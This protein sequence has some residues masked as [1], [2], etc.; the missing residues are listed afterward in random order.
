LIHLGERP[1]L[2]SENV[3]YK[4]H[5]LLNR[6]RL[7]L[8]DMNRFFTPFIFLL[9]A[10]DASAYAEVKVVRTE[11]GGVQVSTSQYTVEFSSTGEMRSLEVAGVEFLK[12]P[13]WNDTGGMFAVDFVPPGNIGIVSDRLHAANTSNLKVQKNKL[14]VSGDRIT[15][16]FLFRESGFDVTGQSKVD[17][18]YLIY[19]P[20][21]N[22]LR[23][24]DSIT[25]RAVFMIGG[26]VVGM[27]QEGMRWPTKQGPMLR[28]DER[29]DGYSKFYWWSDKYG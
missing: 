19:F 5:L 13:A 23:S 16:E 20:S 8:T 26:K 14:T 3:L 21:D 15:L 25:D 17:R 4:T 10:A 9:L 1:T 18:D 6:V 12:P 27:N 22:V 24:L 7:D 29:L 11:K 2:N 28:F